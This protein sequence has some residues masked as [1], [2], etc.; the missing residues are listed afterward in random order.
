VTAL[1][2]GNP[3]QEV[4]YVEFVPNGNPRVHRRTVNGPLLKQQ[5]ETALKKPLDAITTMTPE[6]AT[7]VSRVLF[8]PH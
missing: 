8:E 3:A 7:A 5:I 4:A 1:V 6:E 2:D